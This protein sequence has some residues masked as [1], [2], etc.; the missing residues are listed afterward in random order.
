MYFSVHR[1][2]SKKK[3]NQKKNPKKNHKNNQKKNQ[4]KKKLEKIKD[5]KKKKFTEHIEYESKNINYD[6]F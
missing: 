2:F 4:K 5:D 1:W 3:K 6:L